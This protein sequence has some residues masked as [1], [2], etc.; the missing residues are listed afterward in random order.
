M[1]RNT[2]AYL[3]SHWLFG[4]L[5]LPLLTSCSSDAQKEADLL[6]AKAEQY[7]EQGEDELALQALDSLRHIYPNAIETRRKGLKLKQEISLHQA[8][9]DLAITDSL[10]QEVNAD[11]EYQ[12][13]KVERDKANLRATKEA[14]EM[15]AH[16]KQKRDSLQVRF[17]VQCA[18][19]KYIHRMQK[20]G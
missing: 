2:T 11:Y 3:C 10:L 18:K 7:Y 19:I 5:L 9:E 17:D 6:L 15:L 14:L 13:E 4:L 1:K 12:R 16:T 8:Q 20:E